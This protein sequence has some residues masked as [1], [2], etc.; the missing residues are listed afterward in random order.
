VSAPDG[1]SNKRTEVGVNEEVSM[2][3][4]T[5]ATWSA[6]SGTVT[7]AKDVAT[8]WTAPDAGGKA[9]VTATPDQGSPCSIS[10]DVLPPTSRSLVRV[11]TRNYQNDLAGS[12]FKADATIQPTNVSFARTEVQEGEALADADGYYDTVLHQ[13]GKKHNAT[14]WV[15]ADPRTTTLRDGVGAPEPGTPGPF[16]KGNFSWEIPQLYRLAGSTGKGTT[17]S[18]ALHTQEMFGPSGAELTDKEGAAWARRPKP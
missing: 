7:A 17:Y 4:A 16:S 2:A 13:K 18:K 14:A 9:T 12:G 1:T 3:V 5:P 6:T 8:V 15:R 11:S 10:M